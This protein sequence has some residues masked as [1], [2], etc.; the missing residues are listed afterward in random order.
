MTGLGALRTLA[1]GHVHGGY[2]WALVMSDGELICEPCSRAE[3]RRL[4]R[5][6]LGV[7]RCRMS[8]PGGNSHGFDRDWVVEGLMNSGEQNYDPA[9]GAPAEHCAHCHRVIFEAIEPEAQS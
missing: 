1:R 6:T 8:S 3:Y 9:E 2:R 4:F 7:A 5:N